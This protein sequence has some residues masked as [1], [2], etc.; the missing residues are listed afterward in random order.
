MILDFKEI[1]AANGNDGL[2]DTFELFTRDLLQYLGYR[3]IENPDRGADSKRDLIVEEVVRGIHSEYTIRWLV[4]CKHY[5][6]SGKS[7][8]D[9]DEINIRERIEQHKCDGFMGVYSTLPATSLAGLL[10]GIK[11]HIVYDRER[12]ESLLLR[13]AEG[14][15]IAARYFAESYRRFQ[16][17]NPVPAQIFADNSPIVCEVCGRNLLSGEIQGIYVTLK[18]FIE[19]DEYNPCADRQI[20]EIHFVCKGE[21]D[22]TLKDSWRGSYNDSWGDIDDLKNP[23]IWISS[24]M[25]FINGIQHNQELSDEAFDTMKQMFIRT[26]PYVARHLTLNEKERVKQLLQ[27]GLL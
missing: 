3:I 15:R 11:N 14:Q 19:P 7:V 6:H 21:C 5:A 4:S 12:I 18:P 1:P 13:D 27:F 20:K 23:T 22:N 8:K 9:N 24:F 25:G 16:I 17:E 26:Y 2:Q 10:N